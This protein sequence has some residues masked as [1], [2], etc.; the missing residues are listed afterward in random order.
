MNSLTA[1]ADGSQR[2]RP[3]SGRTT[4]VLPL[5]HRPPRNIPIARQVS[6]SRTHS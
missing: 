5:R 2:Q 4:A 6:T 1:A 3:H